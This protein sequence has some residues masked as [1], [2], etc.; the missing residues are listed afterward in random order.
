MLVQIIFCKKNIVKISWSM[1]SSYKRSLNYL[2]GNFDLKY[3]PQSRQQFLLCRVLKVKLNRNL[4]PPHSTRLSMLI[5]TPTFLSTHYKLQT[6]ESNWDAFIESSILKNNA[7]NANW[8]VAVCSIYRLHFN[9]FRR[10]SQFALK[11]QY[12][13]CGA[14]AAWRINW[15]YKSLLRNLVIHRMYRSL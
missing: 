10:S 9:H 14:H 12:R 13:F 11:R 3:F 2:A 6:N 8:P 5:A 4:F 1:W 7:L 15:A